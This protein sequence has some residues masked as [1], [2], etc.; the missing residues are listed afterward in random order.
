VRSAPRQFTYSAAL[1]HV[2]IDRGIRLAGRM[3]IPGDF[4]RWR[5]ARDVIQRKILEEAWSAERRS[6]TAHIGSGGID[7][8]LLSLPLRRVVEA[9]HPKMV[10]TVE[11]IQSQLGAGGGLLYRYLV[12]EFPDGLPGSD[13]AFLLCS[14]WLVDNLTLQGRFSEALDL[15]DR[16][17]AKAN[18]LG[19]LPEEI[20]PT[21]G[22]FLGNFPQA[23]SHI[24]AICSGVNLY[25]HSAEQ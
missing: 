11:A 1:C 24:G 4:T 19:L 17:C 25:K 2:A 12:G 10:A 22:E 5:S 9:N 23:F 3:T 7:A 16:L 18:S 6:F 15:Y 13:N 8:S 20:D 21:S 14:F